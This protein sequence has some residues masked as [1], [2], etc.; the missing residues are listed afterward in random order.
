MPGIAGICARIASAESAAL[1]AKVLA[2]RLVAK[3]LA[4]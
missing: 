3:G 1:R 4:T 2:A